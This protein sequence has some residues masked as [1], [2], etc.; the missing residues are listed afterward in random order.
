NCGE[1][2]VPARVRRRKLWEKKP[3]LFR[4]HVCPLIAA[5]LELKFS[6]FHRLFD[7]L[8]PGI[9]HLAV[10]RNMKQVAAVLVWITCNFQ[11]DERSKFTPTI[12]VLDVMKS[13]SGPQVMRLECDLLS[14]N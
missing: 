4:S 6:L 5:D 11:R 9:S 3:T 2:E 7:R 1:I 14:S 8:V 13:S 12:S 10:F